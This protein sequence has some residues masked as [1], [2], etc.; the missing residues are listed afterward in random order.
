MQCGCQCRR[1]GRFNRKMAIITGFGH[2]NL[3]NPNLEMA[4]GT[5][6]D[7]CWS[8]IGQV[9]GSLRNHTTVREFDLRLD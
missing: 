4:S 3:A 7:A 2:I 1:I 6:G 9:L 5:S 8:E